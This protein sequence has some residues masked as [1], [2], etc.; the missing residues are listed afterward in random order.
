MRIY[1]V[2]FPLFEVN[3]FVLHLSIFTP[4]YHKNDFQG[5][6]FVFGLTVS[7]ISLFITWQ[8][9]RKSRKIFAVTANSI[10]GQS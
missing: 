8:C 10:V 1:L 6:I 4:N 5:A 9:S 7:L 2:T 3:C